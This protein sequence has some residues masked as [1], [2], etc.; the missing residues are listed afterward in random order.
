MTRLTLAFCALMLLGACNSTKKTTEVEPQ[1]S[2]RQGGGGDR[3]G[4]PDAPQ[5]IAK[6]DTNSDGKLSIGEATGRLKENFAKIDSNSD[7][8]VTKTELESARPKG[9]KRPQRN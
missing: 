5:A 1:T 9:G 7:G 6:M 8:F 3:K 4:A 2:R